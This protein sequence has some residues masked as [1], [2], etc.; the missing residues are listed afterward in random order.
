MYFKV[1]LCITC[2]C[3]FNMD[4]PDG[5]GAHNADNFLWYVP[6]ETYWH[7]TQKIHL[8]AATVETTKQDE[9]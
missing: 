6:A 3:I 8:K 5:D 9:F 1:H 4:N 7:L 2:A